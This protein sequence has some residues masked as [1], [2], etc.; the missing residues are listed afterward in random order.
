[1]LQTKK[2]QKIPQTSS[3]DEYFVQ[4]FAT[5]ETNGMFMKWLCFLFGVIACLSVWCKGR[6]GKNRSRGRLFKAGLAL[7]MG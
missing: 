5:F 7:T 1:M 2:D 3:V 4:T 6:C